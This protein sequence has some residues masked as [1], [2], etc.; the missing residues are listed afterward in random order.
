MS[1]ARHCKLVVYGATAAGVTAAVA[2]ARHG[3]GVTLLEPG[4]HVEGMV[5]GSL[6]YT[7]VGDR[8]AVGSRFS[9]ATGSNG[10]DVPAR[11]ACA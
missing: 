1:G 10:R 4:R 7:D 2:A 9:S 5:S 6:G 11:L 3:V 8:R